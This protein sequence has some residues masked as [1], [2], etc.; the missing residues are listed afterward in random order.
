MEESASCY[1]ISYSISTEQIN[2][3][4]WI[5]GNVSMPFPSETSFLR[6]LLRAWIVIIANFK[7]D[8]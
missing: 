2:H 1:Q 7:T 4:V 3:S 8:L 5:H 6:Y